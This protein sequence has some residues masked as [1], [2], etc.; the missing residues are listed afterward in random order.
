MPTETDQK[1]ALTYAPAKV[2]AAFTTLLALDARLAQ[3]VMQTREVTLGKI[4][5]Q[6]WHDQLLATNS[7]TQTAD[8][9]LADVVEAFHHHDV[10][11]ET[12]AR[13]THGWECLL[14]P[15]PLD[16]ALLTQYACERGARLFE[17]AAQIVGED[18]SEALRA[19]G[20][21]WAL[22]DFAFKCSD[23]TTAHRALS[24]AKAHFRARP[25]RK[26]SRDLRPF[27]LLAQFSAIDVQSDINK[28]RPD[29]PRQRAFEALKFS[30]F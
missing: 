10:T 22:A 23:Q 9:F 26:L 24:L 7:S 25:Q 28:V 3:I 16:D 12:V 21:G 18:A 11:F 17:I 13:L 5:L 15:M 29:S 20:A 8:P 6:W 2:R 30:I 27:A 19:A 4:K 14:E 1:I